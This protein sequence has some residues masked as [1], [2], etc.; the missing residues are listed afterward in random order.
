MARNRFDE[1]KA[2][3]KKSQQE[4]KELNKKRKK[5]LQSV[6]DDFRGNQ[7]KDLLG[8]ENAKIAQEFIDFMSKH[9][10]YG[11]KNLKLEKPKSG[12]SLNEQAI[13]SGSWAPGPVRHFLKR[14]RWFTLWQGTGYPIGELTN[15]QN[16]SNRAFGGVTVYICNDGK[17]RCFRSSL[18]FPAGHSFAHGAGTIPSGPHVPNGKY[19]SIG[20]YIGG[21][22][23]QSQRTFRS[24]SLEELFSGY[25]EDMLKNKK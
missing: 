8:A 12:R 9:G 15:I 16:A 20:E 2:N 22:G 10:F 3:F 7:P 18:I 23:D 6:S 11:A 21:F 14:S 24:R 4:Q 13:R 5:Y 17:L 19:I 25:V 1:F